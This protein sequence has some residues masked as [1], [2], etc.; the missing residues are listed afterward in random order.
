MILQWKSHCIFFTHINILAYKIFLFQNDSPVAQWQRIC[1]QCRRHRF[2]VWV[3]NIPW[4]RKW[5]PIPI[6]LPDQSHGQRILAG[7]SPKCCKELDMTEHMH[8]S[9]WS[10][11]EG[12][13]NS[14]TYEGMAFVLTLPNQEE[15]NKFEML[16]LRK[17]DHCFD[18]LW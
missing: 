16:L 2:N 12:I 15:T 17:I 3:G 13:L 10:H 5:L 1:F 4:R 9:W 7:Y 14:L 8:T 11:N 18:L 6:F